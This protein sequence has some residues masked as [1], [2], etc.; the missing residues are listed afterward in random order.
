MLAA[1]IELANDKPKA[2]LERARRVL[3]A[4][5]DNAQAHFQAALALDSLGSA[6]DA[7]PNHTRR[8]TT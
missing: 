7:L 3:V 5:S 6:A 8:V 1:Q 4:H 2:A